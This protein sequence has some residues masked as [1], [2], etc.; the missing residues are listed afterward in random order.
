LRSDDTTVHPQHYKELRYHPVGNYLLLY[1][2][3]ADGIELV[4]VVHGARDLN[5]LI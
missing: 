3:I 1:R 4:R 5:N 2:V